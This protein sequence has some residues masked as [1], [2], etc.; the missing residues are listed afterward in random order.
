M[1]IGQKQVERNKLKYHSLLCT[2]QWQ[3]QFW[4]NLL[5]KH[6]V[7]C[8]RSQARHKLRTDGRTDR[9][10]RANINPPPQVKTKCMKLIN[11]TYTMSSVFHYRNHISIW[12]GITVGVDFAFGQTVMIQV[13]SVTD[14]NSGRPGFF[15]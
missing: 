15:H 3:Y 11:S 10:T 9:W 8:F 13:C 5:A 4:I 2:R 6:H 12:R 14:S 1:T 7:I